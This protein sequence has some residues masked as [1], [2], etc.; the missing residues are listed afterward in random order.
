MPIPAALAVELDLLSFALPEPVGDL[1]VEVEQAITAVRLAVRSYLGMTVTV[2]VDGCP[3]G[4]TVFDTAGGEGIAASLRIPMAVLGVCHP[5]SSIVFYA[6]TPGTFIDVA[7]DLAYAL[8]VEHATFTL[9]RHLS[10]PTLT[11]VAEMGRINQAVGILIDRGFTPPHG[12]T[13]I[14]RRAAATLTSSHAVALTII[15]A[16]VT[17]STP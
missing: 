11:S 16:A 14:T 13:E 2:V 5:A 9:D 1:G 3:S 15:D 17:G 4:F 6:A 8:H 7:A 10:P 12:Y